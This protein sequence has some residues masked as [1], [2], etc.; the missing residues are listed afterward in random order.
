MGLRYVFRVILV[1]TYLPLRLLGVG[2]FIEPVYLFIWR[3]LL[4]NSAMFNNLQGG[5]R[6][7]D[8]ILRLPTVLV[9]TG[10]SRSLLYQKINEGSFPKQIPLG[11][12]AVG[13][14]EK[15]VDRWIENKIKG[16]A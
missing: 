6:M 8:T 7:A 3:A 1:L 16:A 9:R 15:A 5:A 12:R 11:L 13:F 2:R 4:S 14:S 10:L